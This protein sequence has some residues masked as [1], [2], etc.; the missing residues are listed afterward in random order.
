MRLAR[1]YEKLPTL[2]AD[3]E[4]DEEFSPEE[5][6]SQAQHAAQC[7]REKFSLRRPISAY[8]L[9]CQRGNGTTSLRFLNQDDLHQ[10]SQSQTRT[11]TIG[12]LSSLPSSAGGTAGERLPSATDTDYQ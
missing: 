6:L 12:E 9:T 7:P 5:I 2:L 4:D 10:Q 1:Y 8:R 11:I 3:E